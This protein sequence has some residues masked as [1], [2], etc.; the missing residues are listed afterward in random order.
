MAK[1]DLILLDSILEEEKK[2]SQEEIG[3]VFEKFCCNEIL[4]NKDLTSEE[5]QSGFIDGKDDGGIDY[6]FTF[7]N[8]HLLMDLDSLISPK[9]D[10]SMEI[11]IITSKHHN[12]FSQ[13]TLNTQISTIN[14]IFNLS[15]D[16]SELI[17]CYN[18]S[19]LNQRSL[20]FS[21]YRKFASKLTNLNFKF[22]YVSR[23]DS[24]LLAKNVF[25]RGQQIVSAIKDFFSN[26]S[27]SYNF[28]GAAELLNLYRM[29]REFRLL[30]PYK[31][32][33]S[34]SNQ[35]Y[36]LLCKISDY[37][38]FLR[39]QNGELRRY[40]FDSNVRDYI[41][42]NK[43][44]QDILDT[45]SS[46]NDI[47]FWW[48]NNGITILSSSAIDLGKQIEIDNVQI[49]N[50]LQTSE[51]IFNYFTQNPDKLSD[52]RMVMVKIITE[53][54][55][56][57]RDK[58]IQATNNQSN[59]SEY[60]LHATDK[61]QQ[62]IEEILL[63]NGM[64]YERRKDYYLNQG[65]SEKEIL[66]PLSLAAGYVAIVEK[67]VHSS[68]KLKQ[69]FMR[70]ES[71]YNSVFNK[72]DISIWVRVAKILLNADKAILKKFQE[73]R[74]NTKSEK[75]LRHMLSLITVGYYFKDL[76]YNPKQLLELTIE[77][78]DKFKFDIVLDG[79][80]SFPDIYKMNN[81]ENRRSKLFINQLIEYCAQALGI[82]FKK[83][84]L[85]DKY[86]KDKYEVK[87]KGITEELLKKVRKLLPVQPWPNGIHKNIATT[88]NEPNWKIYEAID[89]LIDRGE[90][91]EQ[92][93]GVLYDIHGHVIKK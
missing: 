55:P 86:K 65:I 82:K 70:D 17:G 39:D 35:K 47:D 13:Q 64:Y 87:K 73:K 49:V 9:T 16:N 51:T 1:N 72:L 45:L 79:I 27:V 58:I 29:K 66:N 75:F 14:E 83:D 76:Q 90:Y 78:I 42:L 3:V 80:Y 46:N 89:M 68:Y 36:I 38:D 84:I 23:G 22:I 19:L 93:N 28:I 4:K 10:I 34:A 44:N 57:I 62:D 24:S 88:L 20:F 67:N 43:V 60:S 12:T 61:I 74:I 52:D 32:A 85:L 56:R 37:F 54:Q 50:G 92:V 48:L 11:Y 26:C 59:V 7:V 53:D 40:L 81:K 91:F 41:G 8:G 5:I 15:L 71:K 69:K 18:E 6:F 25:N 63:K 33:I 2:I 21:A 77:E 31:E 30:L